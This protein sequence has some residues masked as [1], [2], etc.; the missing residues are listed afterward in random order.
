MHIDR[1]LLYAGVFLL[2]IGGV[3][4][5]ADIGLIDTAVL[6]DLLRLWPVAVV[7]LG[8]GLVFRRSEVS[9]ATGMVAAAVPGLL[10]GSAFAVAPR[11]D[12][13]GPG[14]PV[15]VAA[16]QGSFDGPA[17]VSVIAGCGTFDVTTTPGGEWQLA[18]TNTADRA[19]IVEASARSL[20]IDSIGMD[21]WAFLSGGRNSWDLAL[22]TTTLDTLSLELTASQ[23]DVALPD[24]RVGRLV[25]TANASDMVVDAS[26]ASFDELSG[27][28]NVGSMAITL[29]ADDDVTGSIQLGGSALR[30]CRPLGVGL[31]LTTSGELGDVKVN[32]LEQT[33]PVW[34]SPD[35]ATAP[36]RA[37]IDVDADF[38][39]VE[40]DPIGGCK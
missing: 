5:A 4:V 39:S 11:F 17:N 35:Y 14:E 33:G 7:A 10:I 22:P 23:V 8:V 30:L 38:S 37:D 26:Q 6:T 16:E 32:G 15:S 25:L 9:L 28:A 21:E 12:C 40:I 24:A 31:R 3:V 18:A 34:Q 1:R 20:S 2:A 36:Y 13:G 19:P 29:P 27:E